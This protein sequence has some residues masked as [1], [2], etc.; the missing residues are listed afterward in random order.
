VYSN[1]APGFA[2][3]SVP[4][5]VALREA[6]AAT[7]GD[8]ARV[9]WVLGLL[10]V[11]LP[12]VLIVVLVRRVADRF[13]P[14][15]GTAAA[16]VLGGATLLLP[17]ATLFLSHALSA[18]LAFAAFALLVAE[19]N[20]PPRPW[21]AAAAGLLAGL[22]VAVE[23][24]NAVAVVVLGLYTLARPWRPA[25]V[26]AYAAGSLAGAALLLGYTWW[27]YG[28][29][30]HTTY[31]ANAEGNAANLFGAPSLAVALQLFLSKQGLLVIT[32]VLVCALVGIVS[33][34][35]RGARAEAGVIAGITVA[36]VVVCSA[37]YAPFGGFS[38]GP[39]YLVTVLPFLAVALA[40]AFR[41]APVTTAAL[42][43]VS[44]VV[45]AS[46]TA[47]HPL[48]GYDGRW[49]TRLA[50]GDVSLT[51]ARL[52]GVT[53]WYTILPLFAALAVAGGLALRSI[54][55]VS[56]RPL[57]TAGA[58]AAVL[59]WALLAAT[60]KDGGPGQPGPYLATAALVALALAWVAGRR[61][62]GGLLAARRGRM[63]VR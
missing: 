10:A 38:P 57:E 21:L 14:G 9:L 49:L 15:F 36:Y 59:A 3:V 24:P 51:A 60:A 28:S 48:A 19:R 56:L 46:L 53:G 39:R 5:Y 29:L 11:V 16:V 32:P 37:F 7:T 25:R 47:T 4:G 52:A 18:L 1:K 23:Y 44:A 33:L 50:H 22:G 54:P 41:A 62:Q 45:M 20:G 63:A 30:T 27:A 26:L 8:P 6:G 13:E 34:F 2:A 12:A 55:Q 31:D 40:P 17:F 61:L 42:G 58:G 43:L 35:R